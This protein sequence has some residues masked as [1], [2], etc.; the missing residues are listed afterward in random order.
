MKLL[1]IDDITCYTE[2]VCNN[3]TISQRGVFV[4]IL[5]AYQVCRATQVLLQSVRVRACLCVGLFVQK[6][7]TTKYSEIDVT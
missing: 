2:S 5:P 6:L 1:C 3:S 7:K 4:R